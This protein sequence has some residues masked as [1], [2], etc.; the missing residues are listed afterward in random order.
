MLISLPLS[1][2]LML[3]VWQVTEIYVGGGQNKAREKGERV[4][5][6][7][8]SGRYVSYA[9]SHPLEGET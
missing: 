2:S 3:A 6:Y 4:C 1:I 9:I 5:V 7:P 8:C